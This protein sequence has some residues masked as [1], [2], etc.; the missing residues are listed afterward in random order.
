[1]LGS[2]KSECKSWLSKK[3][4]CIRH[5][6]TMRRHIEE[7]R[8]WTHLGWLKNMVKDYVVSKGVLNFYCDNPRRTEIFT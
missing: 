6:T 1:M 4:N 2:C 8:E 5:S 7:A 3:L